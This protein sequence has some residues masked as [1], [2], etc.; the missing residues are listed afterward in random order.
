MCEPCSQAKVPGQPVGACCQGEEGH[1]GFW[2]AFLLGGAVALGVGAG[3]S[4]VRLV[5]DR[6]R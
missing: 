5:V 3:I 1:F 4:I 2:D 6:C